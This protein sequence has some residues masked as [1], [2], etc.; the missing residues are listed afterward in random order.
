MSVESIT[1]YVNESQALDVETQRQIENAESEG[2]VGGRQ[3]RLNQTREGAM[4]IAFSQAL[5]PHTLS[6][7]LEELIR[8]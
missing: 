7:E 3:Y 4:R 5:E 8:S 2:M 6:V 1:T